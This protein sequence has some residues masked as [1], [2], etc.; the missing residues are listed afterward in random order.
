MPREKMKFMTDEM[1]EQE[2]ERL[3][4]SDEVKL[5]KKEQ[6]IIH[7][8]RQYLYKLRTLEKKGKDL[9]KQGYT[10]ENIESR[11]LKDLEV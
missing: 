4:K 8:R 11:L 9:K 5:A 3:V 2:I 6:A 7:K 1:V 10:L